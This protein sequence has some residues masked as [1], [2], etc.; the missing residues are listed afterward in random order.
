MKYFKT[1]ISMPIRLLT[2]GKLQNKTPKMNNSRNEKYFRLFIGVTGE[3][4]F[5]VEG[6][7]YTVE[8]NKILLIPPHHTH[9]IIEEPNQHLEFYWIYF[10]CDYPYNILNHSELDSERIL[11]NDLLDHSLDNNTDIL[12]PFS[13]KPNESDRIIIEYHQLRHIAKSNYYTRLAANYKLTSLLIELS[14]QSIDSITTHLNLN[15]YDSKI[16]KIIDW[17]K[18]N[19]RWNFSISD[20]AAEFN[21]NHDYLSRYF[22]QNMGMNIRWYIQLMRISKAKELL[23]QTSLS[24]KEIAFTVGFGDDKYFLKQFKKHEKLTPTE[25]RNAYFRTQDKWY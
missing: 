11:R 20:L 10:V 8:P 15:D 14:Q 13:F 12:I 3:V 4:H 7:S 2:I 19:Y 17:I 1:D 22:K 9:T 21:Y 5:D 18:R 16:Y 6:E 25:Y 24:V 23:C